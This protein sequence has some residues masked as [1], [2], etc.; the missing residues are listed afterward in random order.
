MTGWVRFAAVAA[1]LAMCGV[2]GG[3]G[4]VTFQLEGQSTF[5]NGSFTLEFDD[6][7]GDSLFSLN[8]LTVFSGFSGA[9]GWPGITQVPNVAGFTDGGASNW[10]FRRG[11]RRITIPRTSVSLQ[12]TALVEDPPESVP[13]PAPLALLVGALGMLWLRSASMARRRPV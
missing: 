5:P 4:A 13:L 12:L 11:S 8:E 2:G 6:L 10:Q 3:A 7:D 1:A 9:G